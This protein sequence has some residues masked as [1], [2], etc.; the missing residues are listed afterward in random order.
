MTWGSEWV[1]I[2]GYIPDHR[3][4]PI[5]SK[6]FWNRVN[7]EVGLNRVVTVWTGSRPIAPWT[8]LDHR[9]RSRNRCFWLQTVKIEISL[10]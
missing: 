6:P 3:P 7:L 8:E 9:L 1:G 4:V 5:R 10:F 2:V